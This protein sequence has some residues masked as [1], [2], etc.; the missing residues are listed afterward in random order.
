MIELKAEME[1]SDSP[2][3]E[4][5]SFDIH[6]IVGNSDEESLEIL[7]KQLKVVE[8]EFSDKLN[9]NPTQFEL[10]ENSAKQVAYIDNRIDDLKE[11]LKENA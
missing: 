3:F 8:E 10:P 1:K 7:V 9:F 5:E 4:A 2:Q 11:L 6:G